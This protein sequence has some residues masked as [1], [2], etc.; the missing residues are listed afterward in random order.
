[1]SF[2]RGIQ[3]FLRN[4][5]QAQQFIPQPALGRNTLRQRGIQLLSSQKAEGNADR[6]QSSA[7]FLLVAKRLRQ[8][9][10][11]NITVTDQN[12]AHCRPGT[13]EDETKKLFSR[14]DS[15]IDQSFAQQGVL[16]LLPQKRVGQLLLVDQ[17]SPHHSFP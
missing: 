1:M 17:A 14:D 6:T 2:Q 4:N 3:L 13:G 8:L 10:T 11:V 15:V 12:F 5:T 9:F 16:L 7:I